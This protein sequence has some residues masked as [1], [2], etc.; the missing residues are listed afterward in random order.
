[1]ILILDHQITFRFFRQNEWVTSNHVPFGEKAIRTVVSLYHQTATQP[2]VIEAHVLHT[3]IRVSL[4]QIVE[5]LFTFFFA[6]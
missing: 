1:M 4:E 5:D 6:D 3:I 2:A